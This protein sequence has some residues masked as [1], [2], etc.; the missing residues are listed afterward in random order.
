MNPLVIYFCSGMAFFAGLALCFCSV[1]LTMP[2]R[3]RGKR[4]QLA[5]RTSLLIGF[6]LVV[7]SA[8][9]MHPLR[10]AIFI[11]LAIAW[12]VSIEFQSP[13]Y[14]PVKRW[15]RVGLLLIIALMLAMEVPYL[16]PPRP[17]PS[18]T[19]SVMVF[20]DSLTAGIGVHGEQTWPEMLAA[21]GHHDFSV[22]AIGGAG[23]ADL[24]PA[25]GKIDDRKGTVLLLLGG[26]DLLGRTRIADFERSL[27]E[28]LAKLA[29]D[30]RKVIIFELPLPPFHGAYGRIQR[31]LAGKYAATLIPK[32]YLAWVLSGKD[33]TVDGLHLSARGHRKLAD[34]VSRILDP[35]SP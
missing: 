22:V 27:D 1:L 10:Y 8:T 35:D 11:L 30:G 17:E 4:W 21:R 34:I 2:A 33:S 32:R 20:G 6:I 5:T 23:V 28:L 25:A 18:S 31:R 9:P 26:N 7:L 12:C 3:E 15:L 19:R 24:I 29:G 16:M 14:M 13:E